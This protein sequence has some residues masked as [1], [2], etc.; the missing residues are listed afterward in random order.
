MSSSSRHES[1][2]RV[3]HY[4]IAMNIVEVQTGPVHG[5]STLP[6]CLAEN[7]IHYCHLPA[8]LSVALP[9]STKMPIIN[10]VP[11][12]PQT[13]TNAAE[14]RYAEAKNSR[15]DV[16]ELH[17]IGLNGQR[18]S[19]GIGGYCTVAGRAMVCTPTPGTQCPACLP[20]EAVL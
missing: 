12:A 14:E 13:P 9:L 18:R 5:K 20:R 6:R 17:M 3:R 10:I 2:I 4:V 1:S 11:Q 8:E 16:R 19:S 15:S 7:Y